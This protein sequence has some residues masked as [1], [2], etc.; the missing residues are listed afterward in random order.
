MPA[1]SYWIWTPEGYEWS[2]FPRTSPQWTSARDDMLA[3]YDLWSAPDANY[4]F[5]LATAGWTLGPMED[6]AWLDRQLPM[7]F[8]ALSGLVGRVGRSAVQTGW[9]PT[10]PAQQTPLPCRLDSSLN[11]YLI[12]TPAPGPA[13]PTPTLRMH[14]QYS[15]MVPGHVSRQFAGLILA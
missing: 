12:P 14:L 5:R 8:A 15:T 9:V 3:A 4:G 13:P 7:D 2:K 11:S 1:P 6:P 10:Y